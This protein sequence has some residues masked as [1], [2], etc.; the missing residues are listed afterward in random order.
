M[1]PSVSAEC[2][3]GVN[4]TLTQIDNSYR[5]VVGVGHTY[6]LLVGAQTPAPTGDLGPTRF[7]MRTAKS[8]SRSFHIPRLTL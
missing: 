2:T 3:K 4:P 1:I 6:S 5:M 8:I 7:A